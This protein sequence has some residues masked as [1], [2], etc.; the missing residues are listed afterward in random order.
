MLKVE[1]IKVYNI[2]R[3]IYSARNALNSWDKSDSDLDNDIVGEKDLE[4]AKKL[5]KAGTSHRKYLRQIFVSM[6]ITAPVY[7]LQELDTYKIGTTRNSSSL[8][9]KG[10][11]RDFVI[12]DISF[13]GDYELTKDL[14]TVLD[15]VN[16]Y[17]QEYIKTNDYMW[18]RRMR[19]I[20][21]MGYNYKFTFTLN[22]ENVVNIILQRSDHRL[23][24][25]ND[26]VAILKDLPYI[27]EITEIQ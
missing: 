23:Q 6:D 26:F 14:Q 25:W 20:M 8:Q 19:Q 22:Y 18:F 7:W 4:L 10:S 9:H 2:A 17:R 1:N 11:S 24:E 15:I 5:F 13:D 21:P 12:E 27:R 3:A 16:R